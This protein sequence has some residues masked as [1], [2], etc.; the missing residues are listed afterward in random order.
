[1]F[2]ERFQFHET[3]PLEARLE[4]TNAQVHDF[5]D[6]ETVS[7]SFEGQMQIDGNVRS[8]RASTVLSGKGVTYEKIFL[9]DLDT[10]LR[11]FNGEILLDQFQ[12]WE[13]L[14]IHLAFR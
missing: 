5:S 14:R 2:K 1:M 6:D 11:F 12:I 3:M 10:S 4:V 7:G 9:G 13:H 8:L